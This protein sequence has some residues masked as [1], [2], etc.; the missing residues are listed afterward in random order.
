[1]VTF[2]FVLVAVLYFFFSWHH[3]QQRERDRIHKERE[4]EVLYELKM[5]NRTPEQVR[6]DELMRD[7]MYA[8]AVFSAE[9]REREGK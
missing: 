2:L 1:M 7:P 6:H 3:D 4:L 9:E 5:A 8:L